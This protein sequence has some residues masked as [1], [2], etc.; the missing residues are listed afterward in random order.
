VLDDDDDDDDAVG[1]PLAEEDDGTD[2]PDPRLDDGT[3]IPDPRLDDVAAFDVSLAARRGE[4]GTDIP[5]FADG[6]L[7]VEPR[8]DMDRANLALDAIE[9]STDPFTAGI[10][11]L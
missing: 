11:L 7:T 6:A 1:V 9:A 2:I 10:S 5:D 8:A 4:E 3:D